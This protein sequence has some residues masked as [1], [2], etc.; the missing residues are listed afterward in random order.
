MIFSNRIPLQS[1]IVYERRSLLKR[2]LLT[3]LEAEFPEFAFRL[4]DSKPIASASSDEVPS[5]S[6]AGPSSSSNPSTFLPPPH[7]TISVAPLPP[8]PTLQLEPAILPDGSRPSPGTEPPLAVGTIANIPALPAAGGRGMGL[9]CT[10]RSSPV[11]AESSWSVPEFAAA[12]RAAPEPVAGR[13]TGRMLRGQAG[14]H[15]N[16]PPAEDRPRAALAGA[17][18]RLSAVSSAAAVALAGRGPTSAGGAAPARAAP[19]DTIER[20]GRARV[21]GGGSGRQAEVPPR[22]ATA[23]GTAAPLT[24]PPRAAPE[25]ASGGALPGVAATAGVAPEDAV[26]RALRG[27]SEDGGAAELVALLTAGERR[28]GERRAGERTA[29]RGQATGERTE[30]E[31][32]QPAAVPALGMDAHTAVA[33]QMVPSRPVLAAPAALPAAVP[34]G[35]PAAGGPSGSRGRD[36]VSVRM[37][38]EFICPVTQ[39]LF[40]VKC[41]F[42]LRCEPKL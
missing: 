33:A 22:P 5:S 38:E 14:G 36:L 11:S 1:F 23:D 25:T 15:G 27:L 4:Q 8:S 34:A 6:E 35:V 24:A 17:A 29:S 37:Q 12:A 9:A 18:A 39:V 21:A 30:T 41:R 42:S 31:H 32:D 7:G 19:E 2:C 13:S 26:E 40:A 16:G 10:G 28:A 3:Y 20:V